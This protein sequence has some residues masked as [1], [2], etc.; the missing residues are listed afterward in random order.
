MRLLTALLAAC[1]ASS[2]LTTAAAAVT[3]LHLTDVH[4]DPYYQIGTLAAGCFCESHDTCA[5][6][7][8]T[9]TH[10]DNSSLAA[11]PFGMPED[12]CATPPGLWEAAMG[13]VASLNPSMVFFTGDFGQAGLAVACSERSPAQ[14]QLLDNIH[15][16][17]ASLRAVL[18]GVPIY[19]VYGNH[20]SEPFDVFNNTAAQSWLYAGSADAMARDFAHDASA[21]ASFMAGGWYAT[22][23]PLPSLTVVGLNVN[24]W[25]RLNDAVNSEGAVDAGAV[26]LGEEQ[27]AW[28]NATLARVAAIPGQ[29]AYILAHEP[30]QETWL[31]GFYT[32]FRVL[33]AAF[34]AATVA[35]SFY[36]HSHVDQFTVVQTC[37]NAAPNGSLPLSWRTIPGLSW[38]SG[39][40]L[41][42]GDV[43]GL[44]TD[45][46]DWCPLVPGGGNVS[47][48]LPLC[49]GVCGA[50][51][52]CAGFTYYPN[53]STPS[54][55]FRTDVSDQPANASSKALCVEKVVACA[56]GAPLHVAYV[57]P[58]LTEGYPASNPG[59][60]TYSIDPVSL[61]VLDAITHW[62]NITAANT[63]WAFLFNERYSAREQYKLPDM[64]P[65]SWLAA[66]EDMAQPG[67]PL[68]AAFWDSYR[69][70]YDGPSAASC[71]G[72][73]CKDNLLNWLNGTAVDL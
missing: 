28:L 22:A 66:V 41:P 24:Y 45:G 60:R 59:L 1:A 47:I 58:S 4:I 30:P 42:V 7:P 14:T 70:G 16:A 67:S 23:G 5:R 72:G 29:R 50:E 40:N 57:A 62:G 26:A 71:V 17:F 55:C 13:F 3:I 51:E 65:T 21:V 56:P 64:S 33:L 49:E 27:F 31:P 8:P 52:E 53:G 25:V 18:P 69:K 15:N 46:N 11:L 36:G 54:C 37:P 43:W 6:F 48:A 44:G 61:E 39:G 10:T 20:D 38:C 68:W 63:A 34:P 9:C 73:V 32:R 19:G 2:S 12:N 35:A